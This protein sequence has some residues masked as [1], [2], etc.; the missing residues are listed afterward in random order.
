MTCT[1]Q[2]KSKK[3]MCQEMKLRSQE[4]NSK[5]AKF[6]TLK[7]DRFFG[8]GSCGMRDADPDDSC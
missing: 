3:G 7:T 6:R 2:R 1:S 8:F 5:E 4:K